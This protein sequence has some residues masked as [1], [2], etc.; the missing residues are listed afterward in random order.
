MYCK[1]NALGYYSLKLMSF[2]MLEN[3][4]SKKHNK[5]DIIAGYD[6]TA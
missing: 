4:D 3:Q 5:S 2:T 6:D 1:V